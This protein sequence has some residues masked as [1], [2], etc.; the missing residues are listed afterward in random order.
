M[1]TVMSACLVVLWF[2]EAEKNPHYNNF[3]RTR[4]QKQLQYEKLHLETLKSVAY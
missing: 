3:K 2:L 4:R 1:T